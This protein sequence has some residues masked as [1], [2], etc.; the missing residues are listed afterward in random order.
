MDKMYKRIGILGYGN[1]GSAIAQGIKDSYN[2]IV[3]DQDRAK[4]KELKGM[5]LAT[6]IE[7]LID[8]SQ[9]V[10]LAIKPQDFDSLLDKIKDLCANKL[11]VSI[12]A[13]ITTDYLEKYL[14]P[15]KVIRVMPNLSL[16]IGKGVSCLCKADSANDGDL[17]FT[18]KIF[19]SLGKT[20]VIE[21][22]LM[23]AAT[24]V[25]GSGPGFFFSLV[26]GKSD[27][28]IEKFAKDVFLP[29]LTKAAEAVGFDKAQAQFL[30][31]STTA[32]SLAMVTLSTLSVQELC[33]QVTSKGG[34]TAA[35]L[36]K[37]KAVAAN[38]MQAVKA[39]KLHAEKLSKKE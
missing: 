38:L 18:Q 9:V 16:K 15:T 29:G 4:I 24:A 8:K 3:F 28:E 20:L 12:A 27:Q 25:S 34:T 19:S 33:L 23:D 36:E 26:E 22:R 1:M 21:E 31:E 5:T 35:G 7:D 17:D 13:G 39:A 6:S 2:L 10:I 30:A 11:I 14:G 32:G 37:L